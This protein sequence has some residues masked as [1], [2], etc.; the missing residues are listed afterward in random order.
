MQQYITQMLLLFQIL[1]L[2]FFGLSAYYPCSVIQDIDEYRLTSDM[3]TVRV[4]QHQSIALHMKCTGTGP[5]TLMYEN[6]L[7]G[8]SIII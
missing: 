8:Q 1:F 3:Y 6:G 2:L 7:A 4:G 5:E